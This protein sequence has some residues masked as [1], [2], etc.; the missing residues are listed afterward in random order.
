MTDKQ[1][2]ATTD[3]ILPVFWHYTLPS[4]IGLIAFSSSRVVDAIFIGKLIG[5]DALAAVNLL[6]PFMSLPFAF[7]FM[8]CVGGMVSAGKYIGEK[9]PSKA[10]EIF[11]KTAIFVFFMG[12][13]ISVVIWV[14]RLP[15][16]SLLGAP[17][18]LVPL[19]SE[20]LSVAAPFLV[21]ELSMVVLYFFIRVDN[22]PH[23]VSNSLIITSLSNVL[24][25]YIFISEMGWGMRGAALATGITHVF[26]I[27]LFS[28]HFFSGRNKIRPMIPRSGWR[29]LLR[30][31][32][33]GFSEF[34]NEVSINV[35]MFIVHWLLILKVG[36]AG[37][38]AISAVNYLIFFGYHI[39]FAVSDTLRIVVSQNLG[40]KQPERV[41]QFLQVSMG[42]T[43][44]F[45]CIC[46]LLLVLFPEAMVSVFLNR[47]EDA[48]FGL[49]L[50]FIGY[51]WPMLIFVGWNMTVSAYLTGVHKAKESALLSLLRSLVLPVGLLYLFNSWLTDV[52]LLLALP[53]AEVLTMLLSLVLLALNP[54]SK[55][56]PKAVPI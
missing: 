45:G 49:A 46:I 38:A 26:A 27:I 29:E 13:L 51:M 56:V 32:A 2:D 43:L 24:L 7:C 47:S 31:C 44:V 40:A 52:P 36:I 53:S 25:D 20:Y 14:F 41:R 21:A 16:F 28:R 37:V 6:I 35:T 5:S 17:E 11:S 33:N 18:S 9:N 12:L 3:A 8:F 34:I 10:S 30:T 23:L 39:F 55:V 42:F 19:M 4:L 22:A 50:E 15:I 1:P 48:A 54:P